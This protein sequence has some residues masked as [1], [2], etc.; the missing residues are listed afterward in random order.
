MPR[1]L[2]TINDYDNNIPMPYQSTLTYSPWTY[3][4]PQQSVSRSGKNPTGARFQ[5]CHAMNYWVGISE[6][7]HF[8]IRGVGAYLHTQLC[9]TSAVS[10]A[11]VTWADAPFKGADQ[12]WYLHAKRLK[13]KKASYTP[14]PRSN[15]SPTCIASIL[16]CCISPILSPSIFIDLRRLRWGRVLK[17]GANVFTQF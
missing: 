15:N 17:F 13:S 10:D 7:T 4:L 2:V 6:P 1:L 5:R 11:S 16:K 9:C 12:T 14:D 8:N 3:E